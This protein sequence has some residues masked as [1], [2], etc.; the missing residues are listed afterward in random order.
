[1]VS[2]LRLMWCRIVG[3]SPWRG[4]STDAVF[5]CCR[6]CGTLAPG[7]RFYLPRKTP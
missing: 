7:R 6:R 5:F 2:A 1:M 4:L 3:H